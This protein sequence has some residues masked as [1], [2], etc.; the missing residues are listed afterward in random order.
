MATMFLKAKTER[1][2]DPTKSMLEISGAADLW[3]LL[4]SHHSQS[5]K[6]LR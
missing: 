1:F 5:L 6:Q 3:N 2:P 4:N